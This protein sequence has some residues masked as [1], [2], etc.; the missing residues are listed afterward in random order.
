MNLN[1]S[2]V[3]LGGLAGGVVWL[4]W[5]FLVG[6]FI[7]GDARYVAAQNAGLFLKEPRYPFFGPVDCDPV[8]AGRHRSAFVRLGAP[9]ARRRSG[10]CVEGWI[11]RRIC[12]G[13][14]AELRASRLVARR[15]RVPSGL[16]A[17]NVGG[18]NPG[19]ASRRMALQRLSLASCGGGRL[20][21]L[22]NRLHEH[23]RPICQH[24]GDTLHNFGGVIAG[25]DDCVS[26]QFGGVLQ[27]QVKG[28]GT[29]LF[30]QIG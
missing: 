16:D 11:P 19:S 13:L 27:H 12:R 20:A 30:A 15:S 8:R 25:A 4:I 28:F 7:I 6:H 26:A 5:S 29:G 2:R 1:R 10:N 18:L 9:N 23:R 24:F 14:P 21:R 17:G 22:S 3:W